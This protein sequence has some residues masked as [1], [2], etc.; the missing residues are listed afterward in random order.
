MIEKIS[1]G[2]IFSFKEKQ[3]VSFIP[4]PLKELKEHL[5]T[6]YLYSTNEK[7]LKSVAVYG[8]N[9]HGKSNFIK[10]YQFIISFINNSFTLPKSPIPVE[11]FVLNTSMQNKP[12]HF[13][14]VFYIGETKYRYGFEVTA[15][16]ICSEWLWYSYYGK[17]ENYLF[18]RVEQEIR[19]SNLWNK[20]ANNK[21]EKQSVPFAKSN[22]L[23][24]SV[25]IAQDVTKV[26]E[27]SEK[28]NGCIIIQ[29]FNNANLLAM[30]TEIFSNHNYKNDIRKFVESADLGFTTIFDK[31]ETKLLEQNTFSREFLN[32]LYSNE[33]KR[34]ELYTQ[35]TIYDE[36]LIPQTTLEFEM[37]KKE[38]DGSIKFFIV[39]SFLVYAIKNKLL[40]WIDE[41]DSRFHSNLLELLVRE[42]HNPLINTNGSQLI[43]TTHNTILLNKQLRRDQLLKVDKDNYG[44]STINKMHTKET[45]LRI[46]TS[47]EKDYRKGKLGGVSK[48]IKNI[49]T[50]QQSLF[51]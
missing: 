38:S 26:K 10:A 1:F 13:E 21:I 34:F 45:P 46:D 33:I 4:E 44:V 47:I 6:P 39:S 50:N 49:N 31:I 51:D 43:F 16:I 17:R 27:I 36:Q 2:N 8:H 12:S 18:D 35:H 19:V 28:I 22:V 5:H 29:D 42:Y 32:M 3:T 25:L 23:L 37:I 41:I 30:A 15:N 11:Q 40:I 48:K 24:L 7:L 20:E 9:S 14:I